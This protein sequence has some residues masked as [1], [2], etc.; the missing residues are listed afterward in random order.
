MGYGNNYGGGY[1]QRQNQGGG[2]YNGGGNG[3]QK[4]N[5]NPP[6]QKEFNLN[7]EIAKRLDILE[8]IKNEAE[9]RGIKTEELMGNFAQWTTSLAIDMGKAGQ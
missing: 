8:M 7:T 1:Q 9:G 4:S 3:Y 5:Y 6:P 2:N